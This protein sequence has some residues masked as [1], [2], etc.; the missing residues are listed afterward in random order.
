MQQEKLSP[1]SIEA[2]ALIASAEQDIEEYGAMVDVT[3]DYVIGA[4]EK[5]EEE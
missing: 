2:Q 3:V 4:G 5:P 1:E